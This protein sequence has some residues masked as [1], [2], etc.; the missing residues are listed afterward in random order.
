MWI[1][2]ICSV[3]WLENTS[4]FDGCYVYIDEFTGFTPKQYSIL[5]KLLKKAKE[6]TIALTVDN[7]NYLNYR[8]NDPFSRTKYTYEKLRKLAMDNGVKINP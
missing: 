6:V 2:K 5:A 4:Y 1:H 7:V 3:H 8:K